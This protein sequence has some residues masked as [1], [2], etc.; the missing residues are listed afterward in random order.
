MIG[1][2]RGNLHRSAFDL[3]AV[4]HGFTHGA[5]YTKT[6]RHYSRATLFEDTHQSFE[7]TRCLLE[8]IRGHPSIVRH[9]HHHHYSRTSLFEDTQHHHYS[10]TPINHSTPSSLFE[11]THQSFEGTRCL[12][13]IIRGRHYSRTPIVIIRGHPSIVRHHHYSRTPINCS[14]PS[15]FED[16]HQ[17]FDTII[18]RG[19]PLFT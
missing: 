14:T 7:G 5:A 4:S 17:S 1:N 9:H 2:Q 6:H 13:D 15:L 3:R 10:R 16:T 19:H 8:I 12:L 18:I 11:D